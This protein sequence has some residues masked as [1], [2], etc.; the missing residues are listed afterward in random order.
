MGVPGEDNKA[1]LL[2]PCKVVYVRLSTTEIYA[3]LLNRTIANAAHKQDEIF[4]DL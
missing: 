2:C 4:K 1:R 3:K